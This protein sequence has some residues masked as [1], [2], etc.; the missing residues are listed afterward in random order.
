VKN[1]IYICIFVFIFFSFSAN[2]IT[3][4]SFDN[5]IVLKKPKQYNGIVFENFEGKPINLSNYNSEIY[6]LN[7]WAT[8]C[9]SCKE[10]IPS[11]DQLQTKEGID[12][13]AINLEKKNQNK[14]KKFF[15]DLNIKNLSIYFDPDLN[16]VKLLTLRGVP[17]TVILNKNR[18]EIARIFGEFDF[19]DKKFFEWLKKN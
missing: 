10:E 3:Q 5:I 15:E 14:T 11:L 6:L 19:S 9:E 17:T 18:E 8:W 13:F 4:P 1:K 7:F 12:V 2:A 16:L